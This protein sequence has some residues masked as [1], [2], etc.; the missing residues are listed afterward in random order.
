M[1]L[2]QC[3]KKQYLGTQSDTYFNMPSKNYLDYKPLIVK[4]D[5][6]KKKIVNEGFVTENIFEMVFGFGYP[7]TYNTPSVMKTYKDPKTDGS[8]GKISRFR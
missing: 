3:T 6:P 5:T 1:R 7:K 8:N 4:S 2:K